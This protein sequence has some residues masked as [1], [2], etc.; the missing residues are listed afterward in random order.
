MIVPDLFFAAK[1]RTAARH[2]GVAVEPTEPARL[3]AD[4]R[5]K[6]P[7]L[8]IVDLHAA[9]GALEAVRA[10]KDDAELAGIPVTGFY[11]HVD[12]A[13]R[14]AALAAGVDQAMPR[15]AFTV[16]LAALLAG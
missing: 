15:S 2:A 4:C 10:L 3:L 14:L 5:A 6:R 7:D 13:A 9:G 11:S 1:I 8:V 16:K 12:E